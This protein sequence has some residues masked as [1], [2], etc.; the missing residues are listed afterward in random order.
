MFTAPQAGGIAVMCKDSDI[1]ALNVFVFKIG[2]WC[3]G[4]TFLESE[5]LL[6]LEMLNNQ[7]EI[8][9]F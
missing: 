1:T 9:V 7:P 8:T 2:S 5:S 3:Y 4:Y 6:G